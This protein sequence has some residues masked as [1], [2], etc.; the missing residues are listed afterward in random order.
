MVNVARM[1]MRA[2]KAVAQWPERLIYDLEVAGSSPA[3]FTDNG[4]CYK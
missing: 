3:R 2:H 1:K 4:R